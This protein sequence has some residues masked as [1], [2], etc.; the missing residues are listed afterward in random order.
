[1]V[2]DHRCCVICEIYLSHT[3]KDKIIE[4]CLFFNHLSKRYD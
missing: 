3:F 1:M 2:Y 4:M